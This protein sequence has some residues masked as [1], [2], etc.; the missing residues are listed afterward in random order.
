MKTGLLTMA[1]VLAVANGFFYFMA[2]SIVCGVVGL[3][4]VFAGGV[5]FYTD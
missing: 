1:T 2:G 4:L 5:V 3:M